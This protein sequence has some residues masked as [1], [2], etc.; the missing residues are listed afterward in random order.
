MGGDSACSCSFVSVS[1]KNDAIKEGCCFVVYDS[2]GK[3]VSLGEL[4]EKAS[5][6]GLEKSENN[7]EMNENN[8][9]KK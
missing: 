2:F 3:P 7:S 5:K 8:D 9:V 6:V 1:I 4:V